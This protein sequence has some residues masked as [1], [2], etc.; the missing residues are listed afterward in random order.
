VAYELRSRVS[1]VIQLSKLMPHR[2]TKA[3]QAIQDEAV[4]DIDFHE[5]RFETRP[6]SAEFGFLWLSEGDGFRAGAMHGVKGT[7]A[8]NVLATKA[9]G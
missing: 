2:S 6:E 3:E 1:R 5:P 7:M 8:C 9:A 4:H